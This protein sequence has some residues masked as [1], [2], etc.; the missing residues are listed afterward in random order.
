[1]PC[2][3][4][5]LAAMLSMGTLA[6]ATEPDKAPSTTETGDAGPSTFRVVFIADTHVIGP[7]YTCCSESDGIDNDSIMKT[8]DRLAAVRDA[9]NALEPQPD[10]VFV[11][12]DVMHDSHVFETEA[13]YSADET[14]WSRAADLFDGFAAPVHLVWGNHDYEVSCD[15]NR[16]QFAASFTHAL[17][18]RF[19]AAPPTDVI[20]HKGW[21]F[22]LANSQ[23]GPTWEPGHPLCNTG[24]A[25]YGREQ[26]AWIDG[27]LDDGMPSMVMAHYYMAVTARSEDPDGPFPGL[28]DVL[29]AH[30]NMQLFLA[31]HMH[32]WIDGREGG[33]FPQVVL[34]ATRYDTDNF[35]LFEFDEGGDTYRI[36]DED[37]PRW[38]TTCA[39]TWQYDPPPGVDATAVEDGDCSF[40]R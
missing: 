36:I 25:S 10:L 26:L 4:V 40:Q 39:D 22:I 12:G 21:R 34:G 27:L 20:D 13:E 6:C 17:F 31:G 16:H 19:F 24:Q 15:P 23:L 11:L 5:S 30:D 32:R 8:P 3:P 33:D 1:M 37:K 18:D 29:A 28:L 38:Y 7:Q 35:W 2:R 14:G 9:V